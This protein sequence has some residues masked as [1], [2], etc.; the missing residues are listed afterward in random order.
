MAS[1]DFNAD[2]ILEMA[3]QIERNGFH[4]YMNASGV[5]EDPGVKKVLIDLAEMERAHEA[6]FESM[7]EDLKG[8]EK[9]PTVFDPEGELQEYC[10]AMADMHVFN[11]RKISGGTVETILLRAI[12]AEKDTIAFFTG[13]KFFVP[14][15][16]GRGRINEVIR[17]EM[18]HIRILSRKLRDV[19]KG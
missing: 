19:R 15:D 12:A 3:T 7:R 17:E 8:L 2:E 10:R 6:T 14:E 4:F 16:R 18:T 1:H 11:D 5:V 13:I 9:D